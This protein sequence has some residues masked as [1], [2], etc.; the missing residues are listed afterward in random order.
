MLLKPQDSLQ[1]QWCVSYRVS[2]TQ[3]CS[4]RHVHECL[5]IKYKTKQ[6]VNTVLH[7]AILEVLTHFSQQNSHICC[8]N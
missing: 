5:F 8:E 4:I 2:N 7:N 6:K 1:I 3:H